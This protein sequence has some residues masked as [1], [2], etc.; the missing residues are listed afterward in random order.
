MV[1]RS[2]CALEPGGGVH[3]SSS[4][5]SSTVP[6]LAARYHDLGPRSRAQTIS[7]VVLSNDGSEPG[8]GNVEGRAPRSGSLNHNYGKAPRHPNPGKRG[9]GTLGA[10]LTARTAAAL[11]RRCSSR[12]S[13]GSISWDPPWRRLWPSLVPK[14]ANS[15]RGEAHWDSSA[16]PLP[17]GWH[18]SVRIPPATELLWIG[19]FAPEI[20]CFLWCSVLGQPR[21][22]SPTVVWLLLHCR[23]Q[24]SLSY[25]H[26]FVAVLLFLWGDECWD[27]PAPPPLAEVTFLI[28]IVTAGSPIS[29]VRKRSVFNYDFFS[30]GYSH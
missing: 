16:L 12:G 30:P 19:G 25:F 9:R 18:F 3:S 2:S 14:A 1:V 4:S 10:R 20:K 11:R 28:K 23:S 17:V 6:V 5:S 27:L 15:R 26:Q 22:L 29:T 21:F 13:E 8:P 24:L 7:Q